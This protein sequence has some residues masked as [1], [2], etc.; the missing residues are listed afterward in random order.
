MAGFNKVIGGRYRIERELGRGGMGIVCI[1]FDL[2]LNR[3]VAIK[4]INR[5]HFSEKS[6]QRF[7]NEIGSLARLEHP[8]IIH[9]YDAGFDQF[10]YYVMQYVDGTDL[11]KEIKLKKRFELSDALNVLYKAAA[12]L[13]FAH[14]KGFVHRDVKPA[15]ILIDSS[16]N[17]YLADFG[18]SCSPEFKNI[19]DSN[20][21]GTVEYASPEHLLGEKISGRSDQYSLAAVAYEMFTGGVPFFSP[22]GNRSEVALKQVNEPPPDP[23]EYASLPDYSVAAILKALSKR[24]DERFQSCTIFVST[25]AGA[26]L[27]STASGML[28][29]GAFSE[30]FVRPHKKGANQPKRL[31]LEI[32]KGSGAVSSESGPSND[33]ARNSTMLIGGGEAGGP[34]DATS[35]KSPDKPDE[36]G[37]M[38]R[39]EDKDVNA[40]RADMPDESRIMR[41]N[42]I[43]EADNP[44]NRLVR[45]KSSSLRRRRTDRNMDA[46]VDDAFSAQG[47]SSP[48]RHFSR[49]S[50]E[51]AGVLGGLVASYGTRVD[52]PGEGSARSALLGDFGDVGEKRDFDASRSRFPGSEDGARSSSAGSSALIGGAFGRG[53]GPVSVRSAGVLGSDGSISRDPDRR[54]SFG[55]G[56]GSSLGGSDFSG[57][58][59][60]ESR[61][62]PGL[63]SAPIREVPSLGASRG[64]D[65]PKAPSFA[66]VGPSSAH[67]HDSSKDKDSEISHS[68]VPSSGDADPVSSVAPSSGDSDSVPSAH[69]VAPSS[70]DVAPVPSV[71]PSSGDVAPVPSVVSQSG[72]ADPVPS[73]V[74]SSGDEG[75]QVHSDDSDSQDGH[76]DPGKSQD[77]DAGSESAESSGSEDGA[78]KETTGT[79]TFDDIYGKSASPDELRRLGIEPEKSVRKEPSYIIDPPLPSSNARSTGAGQDQLPGKGGGQEPPV[80]S[81]NSA[82]GGS[83]VEIPSLVSYEEP[84]KSPLPLVVAIAL[85]VVGVL[86][87]VFF[88]FYPG[89]NFTSAEK[90]YSTE[91]YGTAASLYD[92][93]FASGA[94]PKDKAD[95]LYK[96][97]FSHYKVEEYDKACEYFAT[98][99]KEFPDKFKNNVDLIALIYAKDAAS[100]SDDAKAVKLYEKSVELNPHNMETVAALA[101][102]YL[103]GDATDKAEKVFLRLVSSSNEGAVEMDKGKIYKALSD[104]YVSR[105]DFKS[106]AKYLK[107]AGNEG[108]AVS[109]L[110]Y[111]TALKESGDKKKTLAEL[112]KLS[113]SKDPDVLSG[114]ASV[115]AD[116]ALEKYSGAGKPSQEAVSYAASAR[117]ADPSLVGG[118]ANESVKKG[119]ELYGE[120]NYKEALKRF[121]VALLLN[122]S[123]PEAARKR[124]LCLFKSGDKDAVLEEAG[125]AIA[126]NKSNSDVQNELRGL[127]ASIEK[128]RRP[129]QKPA[130]PAQPASARAYSGSSSGGSSWTPRPSYSSPPAASARSAAPA[131]PAAP[132]A[133]PPPK[134]A[135]AAP[136]PPPRP[137]VQRSAIKLNSIPSSEF[138]SYKKGQKRE[139]VVEI[140]DK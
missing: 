117:K 21:V 101:D 88:V 66:V 106:A 2:Q 3:T 31:E 45:D 127:V 105:K 72:D 134:A 86:A 54:K 25:L 41:T 118:K 42:V 139:G 129:A 68:V 7:L 93:A 137:R 39:R 33:S 74:S 37:F 1:A 5:S 15:N 79:L 69:S 94:K 98:L 56:A 113:A 51:R 36:L 22:S 136:P 14:S 34:V 96:A 13:D 40:E 84:K 9:I 128:E 61:R 48:E 47:V 77:G 91:E 71:V 53:D 121:N 103:K 57:K 131:A 26:N 85:L 110:P 44:M 63:G 90:K 111:V 73:V 29:G 114:Y 19:D 20:F 107:K 58:Y 102:A 116:L 28:R 30:K 46:A 43:S 124:V 70:G 122:P 87:A 6:Y 50:S 75:G 112:K 17:V 108:V 8:N 126:L 11:A 78:E 109:W 97:G 132:K 62:K 59:A 67:G 64:V 12:A 83:K 89:G 38:E 95:A 100:Q 76:A 49:P 120:R 18:L 135:K 104:I 16:R 65:E 10:I 27:S 52:A 55:S 4:L 123:S 119:N 125:R 133:A 32:G 92:R 35:W 60:F 82:P 24:P 115:A 130:Q 81:E 138:K 140:P 80:P 23:R 99:E